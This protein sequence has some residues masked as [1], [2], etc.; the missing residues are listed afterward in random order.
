MSNCK[1]CAHLKVAPDA[2]GRIVVRRGNVYACT[3]PAPQPLLPACITDSY[4]FRWPPIRKHMRGDD[5]EGC[6]SWEPR[7]TGGARKA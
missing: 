7:V 5:G 1:T 4:A 2:A 3:V 6:P